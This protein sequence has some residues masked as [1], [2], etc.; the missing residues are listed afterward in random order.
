MCGEAR[1]FRAGLPADAVHAQPCFARTECFTPLV[2]RAVL[3]MAV[4]LGCAP[5][6][7]ASFVPD[8]PVKTPVHAPTAPSGSAASPLAEPSAAEPAVANDKAIELPLSVDSFTASGAGSF[9]PPPSGFVGADAALDARWGKPW[10]EHVPRVDLEKK[11]FETW[12]VSL[13][14]LAAAEIDKAASALAGKHDLPKL[15]KTWLATLSGD[16]NGSASEQES[17]A[18]LLARCH[19]AV[20]ELDV[21]AAKVRSRVAKAQ[22]SWLPKLIE[23]ATPSHATHIVGSTEVAT[24]YVRSEAEASVID[25]ANS[26]LATTRDPA[27]ERALP[28]AIGRNRAS[29]M[30]FARKPKP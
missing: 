2:R 23:D 21:A 1:M 13:A 4:G 16:E 6:E 29:I 14:A 17:F 8:P 3:A 26:L 28:L 22:P 9:Q 15:R 25:S 11:P 7:I 30:A 5:A 20:E 24:S 19:A 12:A 10:R 18:R 27:L